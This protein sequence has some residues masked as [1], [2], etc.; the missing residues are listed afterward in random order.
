MHKYASAIDAEYISSQLGHHVIQCTEHFTL[1]DA[2]YT[3]ASQGVNLSNTLSVVDDG[4]SGY[5]A[6][7]SI[8]HSGNVVKRAF[9]INKSIRSFI[10]YSLAEAGLFEPEGFTLVERD[11]ARKLDKLAQEYGNELY[12]NIMSLT[13]LEP[14][15]DNLLSFGATVAWRIA[16]NKKIRSIHRKLYKQDVQ[17]SVTS[18]F[19]MATVAE[20]FR[21]LFIGS[22]FDHIILTGELFNDA[23]VGA[24]VRSVVSGNVI[25][26][27]S[28]PCD[29]GVGMYIKY[30]EKLNAEL[31]QEST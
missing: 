23:W 18:Y 29:A 6:A 7:L 30:Q 26:V 22:Q 12:K 31:Q 2:L 4:E 25:V 27:P 14:D 21:L 17:K 15:Y 8:Y 16:C 13:R 20:V 19:V 5:S 3:F 9:G 11:D 10:S 24:M 28:R 1:H